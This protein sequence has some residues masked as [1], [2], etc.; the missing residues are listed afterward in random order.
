MIFQDFSYECPT[1]IQDA[2]AMLDEAGVR[3]CP[4]AGGTDLTIGLRNGW[5]L[6]DR[7]VDLTRIL[8]LRTIQKANQVVRIGAAVTFTEII[9]NPMLRKDLPLLVKACEQV[10]CDQIRN[11]GTIGG[12]VANAAVCADSLPP[13]VCLGSVAVIQ[14]PRG[15]TRIPISEFVTG[16]NQTCMPHGGL[17]ESIEIPAQP[18]GVKG[19]FERI[20]RRKAMAIARLSLAALG[21]LGSDGRISR[22]HLVPGAAFPRFMRITPVEDLLIGKQPEEA[23]FA[24]AG[25]AMADQFN[26][27]SGNRWSAEWKLKAMAAITE[28]ALRQVFGGMNEN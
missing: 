23:L 28:R 9:N 5:I 27:V 20:G 3:S 18:A 8:E 21:S 22:V 16:P 14:S 13:L 4:I 25:Q 11:L 7:L 19:A 17:I 2:V 12:N 26:Q 10:G 1:N 6:V 15:Q 24:A